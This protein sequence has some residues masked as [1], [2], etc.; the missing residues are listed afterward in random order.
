[1]VKIYPIETLLDDGNPSLLYILY[2]K[3]PIYTIKNKV[4]IALR[5]IIALK[6]L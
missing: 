5:I 4:Q 2:P 6:V 3:I 1:V